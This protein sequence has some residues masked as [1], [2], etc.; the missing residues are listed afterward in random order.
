M[1]SLYHTDVSFVYHFWFFCVLFFI[2]ELPDEKNGGRL[3]YEVSACFAVLLSREPYHER[4][5]EASAAYL[6]IDLAAHEAYQ[7]LADE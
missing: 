3:S 7:A 1:N 6:G 5:I 4:C 2:S